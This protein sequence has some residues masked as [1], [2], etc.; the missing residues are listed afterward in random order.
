MQCRLEKMELRRFF[1]TLVLRRFHAGIA[2][3][4]RPQRGVAIFAAIAAG[5]G[6]DEAKAI[7]EY[8]SEP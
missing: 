5:N 3:E 6:K 2:K 1:P 7:L 4:Q 8:L